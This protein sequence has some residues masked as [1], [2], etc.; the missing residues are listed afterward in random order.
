MT[1]T[2]TQVYVKFPWKAVWARGNQARLDIDLDLRT[3]SFWLGYEYPDHTARVKDISVTASG[4]ATVVA[5]KGGGK[6][7]ATV[8]IASADVDLDAVAEGW[9]WAVDITSKVKSQVRDRMFKSVIGKSIERTFN[10]PRPKP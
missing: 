10:A 4:N 6:A 8:K 7:T 5:P 1:Q 3:H 2:A 9:F